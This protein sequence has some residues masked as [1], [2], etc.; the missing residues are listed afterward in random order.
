MICKATT[1]SLELQ[2]TKQT[3]TGIDCTYRVIEGYSEGRIN[4]IWDEDIYILGDVRRSMR[5]ILN[6]FKYSTLTVANLHILS[7]RMQE[8]LTKKHHEGLLFCESLGNY[9]EGMFGDQKFTKLSKDDMFD[10]Y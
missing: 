8:F 7:R 2:S 9:Y 10:K 3:L 1:K 4:I 6:T 5:D